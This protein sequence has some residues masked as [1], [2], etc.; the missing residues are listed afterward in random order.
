[1][2]ARRARVVWAQTRP[3]CDDERVSN[4]LQ[5]IEWVTVREVADELGISPGK[6]RRLIE[7][8]HFIAQKRGKELCIP[9]A[10]VKDGAP[11]SG[12]RGT[13]ILLLDTGMDEQEALEWL[14]SED[15][16]LGETPIAALTAGRK[17]NVR[18]S[19][20]LLGM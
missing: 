6:V 20:Q 16:A 15:D 11:L 9:A 1:M 19:V 7:E 10:M 4:A 3:I 17:T 8:R 2:L 14:F 18:H 12:L 5:S 13:V